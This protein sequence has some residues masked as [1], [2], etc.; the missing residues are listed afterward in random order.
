VDVEVDTIKPEVVITNPAPNTFVKGTVSIDVHVDDENVDES[1]LE[2]NLWVSKDHGNSWFLPDECHSA[3]SYECT[4]SWDTTMETEGMTFGL[5]A[6]VTDLADNTGESEVVVVIVD[7]QG[8]DILA[9]VDPYE[10]EIVS[11][12]TKLEA[13]ASDFVSGIEKVEFYIDDAY[14]GEDNNPLQGWKMTWDS[15]SVDDGEHEIYAMAFD[16]VGHQRTSQIVIFIVDNDDPYGPDYIS[17]MPD[18]GVDYGYSNDDH[19]TWVWMPAEDDGSGV[20]Y[21][22]LRVCFEEECMTTKIADGGE[23]DAMFFTVA[24]LPDGCYEATVQAVD[25]AGHVGEWSDEDYL[26]VDTVPPTALAIGSEEASPGY[27]DD[28]GIYYDDDGEF[29]V[30]WFGGE[31]DN[32]GAYVL[33]RNGVLYKTFAEGMYTWD[34]D[35]DD[36]T[37]IYRIVSIDAA[38]WETSSEEMTVVVD[39]QDPD[40]EVMAPSGFMGMWTFTFDVS[41]PSPSSGIDRIEVSDSNTP[42]VTCFDGWCMVLGGSYVELTAYDMAGNSDTD[43]TAGAPADTTA[44]MI[45]YTSP[46][47]VIFYNEVTL[48]VETNEPALCYYSEDD[49]LMEMESFGE[50]GYATGHS[51]ELGILEDGLYVYHVQCEDMSDNWMEHSKTIV[52]YVSTAGDWCY[53]KD[54]NKGWNSF[55]LPKFVLDDINFNCGQEP[56]EPEDVLASLYSEPDYSIVWYYD[57]EMGWLCFDPELP[58]YSSLTEFNDEVSNP[59]FIKM[60]VAGRIELACEECEAEGYCGDGFIDTGL[61]EQCDYG[62]GNGIPCE[63]EYGDSCEYCS[64]EC[65]LEEVTGGYCGDEIVQDGYEECETDNDCCEEYYC[66]ECICVPEYPS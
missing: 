58:Q 41:D 27:N 36:G 52:F 62:E 16:N 10:G 55:F 48:D 60:K 17:H 57:E 9:I 51:A 33:Y 24:D 18:E 64:S 63:P 7:N 29:D 22:R 26:C 44:P 34:E 13:V 40:I 65:T 37:Y 15:E 28:K 2:G 35:V 39:S 1:Y 6:K 30:T 14:V 31:D 5:K 11:G 47:G 25:K 59:Y 43:S 50:S 61:E 21:Y 45:T 49:D 46:S 19:V 56:Y 12:T 42:Y 32:F 23:I 4:F 8:A 66:I 38:E 53:V 54:L 3:E 20:D